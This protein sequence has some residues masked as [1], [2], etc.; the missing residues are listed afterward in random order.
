MLL[1]IYLDQLLTQTKIKKDFCYL[2]GED[3]TALHI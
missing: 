2:S 1:M 3:G